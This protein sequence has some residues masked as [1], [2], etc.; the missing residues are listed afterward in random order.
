MKIE[1]LEPKGYCA[2]VTIAIN[3]A[4]KA[5]EENPSKNIYVLGNLVHNNETNNALLNKGIT[6]LDLSKSTPEALINSLKTGDV[7]VFPAHGHDPK[8]D[9]LAKSKGLIVYD[10][11]CPV[12]KNNMASI[13]SKIND[14][15]K[16]IFIGK[17]NHP[18]TKAMLS[19]NSQVF[20]YDDELLKNNQISTNDKVFV[21]NQTTL[22]YASLSDIYDK[23]KS[24][25]RFAEIQNEVCAATRLRQEKLKSITSDTDLIIVVGSSHSNNTKELYEIALANPFNAPVILIDNVND[26]MGDNKQLLQNKNHIVISSGASTPKESVDMIKAYIENNA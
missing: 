4:Y 10:A 13:L 22:N 23:I 25:F 7:L 21:A 20:L 2:G 26:L 11:T 12:V 17:E 14:G 24:T 16:V 6:T 15:Y 9:E 1:V 3:V 19:L 18:E 5:K 8:L